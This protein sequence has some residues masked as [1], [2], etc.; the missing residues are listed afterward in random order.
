VVIPTIAAFISVDA[1]SIVISIR[2]ND[3]TQPHGPPRRQRTMQHER[4]STSLRIPKL[5]ATLKK[6]A[7]SL[8][9]GNTELE[10]ISEYSASDFGYRKR[11]FRER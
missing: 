2:A 8:A 6:R 3:G 10:S 9:R 7:N 5:C 11:W 1:G 4:H